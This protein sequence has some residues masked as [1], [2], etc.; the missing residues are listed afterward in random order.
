MKMKNKSKLAVQVARMG[1]PHLSADDG[2]VEL[3]I[4]DDRGSMR[5]VIEDYPANRTPKVGD[6]VKFLN[7]DGKPGTFVAVEVK[8]LLVPGA[9]KTSRA[10]LLVVKRIPQV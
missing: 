6:V 1:M 8:H 10:V 2:L 4:Q 5:R 3:S 9:R 7:G